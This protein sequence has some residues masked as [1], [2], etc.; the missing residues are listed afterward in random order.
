VNKVTANSVIP[1]TT[2]LTNIMSP[3]SITQASIFDPGKLG[4]AL[5]PAL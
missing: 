2:A 3:E 4:K 5:P 1:A